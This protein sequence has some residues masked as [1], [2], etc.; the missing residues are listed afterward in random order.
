MRI[1]Q[2]EMTEAESMSALGQKQTFR[3]AKAMSALPPKADVCVHSPMSANATSRHHG[4]SEV[5]LGATQ[6][7]GSEKC[8][9]I[10]S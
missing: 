6:K 3:D 8:G 1:M 5:G 9:L 4:L 2:T 10:G 7:A